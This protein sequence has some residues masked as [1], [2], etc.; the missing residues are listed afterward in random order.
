MVI[1]LLVKDG[2]VEQ[3]KVDRFTSFSTS[4]SYPKDVPIVITYHT[5]P[6]TK[7]DVPDTTVTSTN[8]L[9]NG[10]NV[11]GFDTKANQTVNWYGI[12]F[13]IPAYYDVLDK[14][15]TDIWKS[16]YPEKEE[17]YASILFQ[18]QDFA[19]TDGDFNS[20]MPSIV[21]D[22]ING[23]YFKNTKIE[24]SE[25]LSI[26]GLPGWTITFSRADTDGDGVVSTGRYS[27]AYNMNTGKIVTIS[28]TFDSND[29]SKYDYFGDYLKVLETAK[30]LVEPL[31]SNAINITN[32]TDFAAIMSLKDPG[33]P[34]VQAFAEAHKGDV[35]EFDG[36]VGLILPH[37]GMKTRFDVLLVGG[38]YNENKGSGAYFSFIDKNFYDMKVLGADTVTK[39]MDFHITG[40]IKEY[41]EEGKFIE[42]DPISLEAR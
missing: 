41:N 7:T 32:S 13:S 1:G 14:R 40:K 28:C 10:R 8:E 9:S 31:N 35:V 27:F 15:S 24:K 42:I 6:S 25:K 12:E 16:Y 5:F 33:D 19:G 11:S 38:D 3:V 29:Q 4:S 22:T 26:A 39:G 36:C 21:K 18:S 37:T 23:E 34:L 30:L 20:Q 2:N 17:Y